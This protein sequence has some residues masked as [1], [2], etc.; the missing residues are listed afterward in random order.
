MHLKSSRTH[1]HERAGNSTNPDHR[2]S[3]RRSSESPADADPSTAAEGGGQRHRKQP[4]GAPVGHG[5]RRRSSSRPSNY[6]EHR[7]GESGGGS[8]K[9]VAPVG[10]IPSMADAALKDLI[11]ASLNEV[12]VSV[13]G[14]AYVRARVLLVLVCACVR[15]VRGVLA[16]RRFVSCGVFG[17]L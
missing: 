6:Q 13:C 12:G 15:W 4:S 8:K 5:H 14:S 10:P 11:E 2:S 17:S 9:R 16:S 7:R 3:R 1:T